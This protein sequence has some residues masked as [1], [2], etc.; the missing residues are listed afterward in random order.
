MLG[1]CTHE[2]QEEFGFMFEALK[3]AIK[4]TF[5]VDFQPDV[6]VADAADAITNGFIKTFGIN[7]T[8]VM[9]YAHV[10]R[11]VDNYLR[12]VTDEEAR[13][14]IKI[15]IGKLHLASSDELFDYLYDKFVNK[16]VIYACDKA[17]KSIVKFLEYFHKEWY[18][19][20]NRG[21]YEGAAPRVPSHNNG[22]ESNNNDIK[23]TFTQRNR[24]V[25]NHYI[26]R[27][28][29]MIRNWS[30]DRVTQNPFNETL[31]L[32]ESWWLKA[33]SMKTD[34]IILQKIDFTMDNM[35]FY[36]LGYDS[37]K[38]QLYSRFIFLDNDLNIDFDKCIDL[39]TTCR[40][41]I[42]NSE[43]WELSQCSCPTF[44]KK[45]MC[46]HII[47]VALNNERTRIPVKVSK[48][49]LLPK[50]VKP[51]PKPKAKK[52]LVRQ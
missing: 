6:L 10:D 15:D 1:I 33:T 5:N 16:W 29:N 35:E 39:T 48:S 12:V 9:C 43:N 23:R 11:A 46:K 40:T 27:C 38:L 2:T 47:F 51:G 22:V 17:D 14:N 36:I 52:A 34:G 30:K 25:V 50:K 20:K 45:Y 3:T 44:N 8:R 41:I 37:C 32:D 4:D 13:Q 31:Y 42:L 26:Q 28:I 18:A 19:S 49:I 21:W 7:F 24:L